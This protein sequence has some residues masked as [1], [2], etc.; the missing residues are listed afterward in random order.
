[1]TL[2]SRSIRRPRGDRRRDEGRRAGR[3]LG[4]PRARGGGRGG[5][6]L[7]A[8]PASMPSSTLIVRTAGEQRVRTS[9]LAALLRGDRRRRG[10]AGTTYG[11]GARGALAEYGTR[12]RRFGGIVGSRRR[13]GD[14]LRGARGKKGS[15]PLDGGRSSSS[16]CSRPRWHDRTGSSVPNRRRPLAVRR[17]RGVRGSSR[18]ARRRGR[19]LM[20]S[21]LARAA[22]AGVGCLAGPTRTPRG[23]AR[24]SSFGRGPRG[25]PPALRG[26][27]GRPLEPLATIFRSFTWAFSSASCARWGTAPTARAAWRS[28]SSSRRRGDI[29]GWAVGKAVG[30]HKMIRRYRREDVG[31]EAGGILLGRR[32]D[33]P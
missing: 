1:M 15:R 32:R 4:P 11:R 25:V 17:G 13:L 2:A 29:G 7:A 31:G 5:D 30:R 26:R 8:L 12:V 6:P 22:L 24:R 10:G 21:P 19:G 9:S 33:R 18:G 3:A 28:S 20:R 27:A 16:A 14:P 23:G